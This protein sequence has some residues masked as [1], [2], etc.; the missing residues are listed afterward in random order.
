MTGV[1]TAGLGA[2]SLSYIPFMQRTALPKA[3]P[4]APVEPVRPAVSVQ[5]RGTGSARA[6][7]T[8]D[9]LS[10]AREGAD[11]AEMAV[12]GRIQRLDAQPLSP[13]EVMEQAQCQTCKSRKYQDGSDDPGVS[14]KTAAHIAPE[15]AAS[16]VR[17]HEMEHVGREQDK[18]RRE[19]RRVVF[20]S[21][22]LYTDI[23]P[24][25]GEVY[26]SGGTTRTV[27]VGQERQKL[28]EPPAQAA[29]SIFEAMA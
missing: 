12:R 9:L 11:P 4:S 3:R 1:G 16:A 27:T 28:F 6:G 10:L 21:V 5:A 17:G 2:A 25:C 8:A 18:A 13:A 22:A 26:A 15:S 20:Q 29:P 7:R 24:E 23:C 19:G 14:F